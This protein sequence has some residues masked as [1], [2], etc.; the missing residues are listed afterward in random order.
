[1]DTRHDSFH[2]FEDKRGSLGFA[3]APSSP[4]SSVP[5]DFDYQQVPQDLQN[6]A[7]HGSPVIHNKSRLSSASS[8]AVTGTIRVGSPENSLYESPTFV[9]RSERKRK[10][11]AQYSMTAEPG[12]VLQP[13]TP[14]RPVK[15]RKT[16]QPKKTR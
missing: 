15:Q 9:R 16:S 12:D 10:A 13:E 5:E 14:E 1:M 8:S 7:M 3:D 4:L 6:I 11:V 2:E